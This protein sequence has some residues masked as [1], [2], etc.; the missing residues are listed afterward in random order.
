MTDFFPHEMSPRHYPAALPGH[1]GKVCAV[2]Q[3]YGSGSHIAVVRYDDQPS[4]MVDVWFDCSC[5]APVSPERFDFGT[6]A[7]QARFTPALDDFRGLASR[8]VEE[9]RTR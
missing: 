4:G 9:T 2:F 8:H 3:A 7:G 6:P 5:G 1:R